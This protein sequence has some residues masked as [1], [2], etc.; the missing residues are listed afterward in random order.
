VQLVVGVVVPYLKMRGTEK[1]ALMLARGFAERGAEVL[2]FVVQGWGAPEMYKAFFDANVA[3]VN[4]GPAIDVGIKKLNSGR[5]WRLAAL[6]RKHRCN[7]LLSRVNITNRVCGIAGILSRIPTV[8]VLSGNVVNRRVIHQAKIKEFI[9]CIRKYDN[10]GYP[11]VIVSVSQEGATAFGTHYPLLG[12]RIR[13]IRNGVDFRQIRRLSSEKPRTNKIPEGR[14]LVGYSGSIE[15]KR[16]GLDTLIQAAETLVKRYGHKDL[17]FLLVGA[18]EDQSVLKGHVLASE[19]TDHVW[20]MGEME[21]PHAVISECDLF[22]LPSR[23]EG[24]PNALLEAMAV[25]VCCVAADCDTGPREIIQDRHNGMLFKVGD[26]DNLA[27]IILELKQNSGLR[28]QL[29]NAAKRIV[30]DHFS[31]RQMVE[32]YFEILKELSAN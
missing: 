15:M 27:K 2:L 16:K 12:P 7:V 11:R 9:N 20:F 29:A 26:S 25:D 21:N 6:A 10:L 14:F 1:Q 8:V 19:L 23:K 22:V 30:I 28:K 24:M 4:V 13:A 31:H 17:L 32:Q 3:V 18:G 5:V